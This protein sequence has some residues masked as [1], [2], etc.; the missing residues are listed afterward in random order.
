MLFINKIELYSPITVI[1]A[2]M[3]LGLTQFMI[4]SKHIV[5]APILAIVFLLILTII[6]NIVASTISYTLKISTYE[7]YEKMSL[8]RVLVIIISKFILILVT[9]AT[10]KFFSQ[11]I[12][13]KRKYIIPLFGIIMIMFIITTTITF[14]D[15]KNKNVNSV[16][17][18]L[19]L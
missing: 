10:S 6:D 18:I 15:I 11:K 7:M 14:I 19:F 13:I 5:K 4:Y 1:L 3:L 8:Y 9:V 2:F 17:Y 12:V 16:V